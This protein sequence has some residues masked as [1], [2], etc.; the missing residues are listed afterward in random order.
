MF[1]GNIFVVVHA[2]IGGDAQCFEFGCVIGIDCDSNA[3]A[4]LHEMFPYLH[5]FLQKLHQRLRDEP[6]LRPLPRCFWRH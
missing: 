2:Q 4:Y 6:G 5:R 1:A 3:G